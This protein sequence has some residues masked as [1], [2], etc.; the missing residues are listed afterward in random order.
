MESSIFYIIMSVLLVAILGGSYF[1]YAKPNVNGNSTNATAT[2][3]SSSMKC[4][5]DMC[6]V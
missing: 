2:I 6:H 4:T 5:N 1:Y 3:E